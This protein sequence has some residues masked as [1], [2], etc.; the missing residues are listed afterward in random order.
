MKPLKHKWK[1]IPRGK[2]TKYYECEMCGEHV[3]ATSKKG[4][5]EST[6]SCEWYLKKWASALEVIK[7]I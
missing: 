5:D 4:A 2:K 6:G 1:I 7:N 3:V